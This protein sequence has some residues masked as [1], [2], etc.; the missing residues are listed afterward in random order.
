M[1]IEGPTPSLFLIGQLRSRSVRC[2]QTTEVQYLLDEQRSD[3]YSNA[4]LSPTSTLTGPPVPGART[5][6]KCSL[7]IHSYTL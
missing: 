2:V 6:P 5:E 3:A 4:T 7:K 1:N